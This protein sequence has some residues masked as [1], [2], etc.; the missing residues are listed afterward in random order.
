[1]S[2]QESDKRAR[3]R[4][5][6]VAI[7]SAVLAVLCLGGVFVVEVRSEMREARVVAELDHLNLPQPWKA[8]A[9]QLVE[10]SS[11]YCGPS[12]RM[13]RTYRVP[14]SPAAALAT[15]EKAVM[16]AGWTVETRKQP[17][18]AP[19]HETVWRRENYNLY[20]ETSRSTA[21]VCG[22]APV[23]TQVEIIVPYDK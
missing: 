22:P 10:R 2:S 15:V 18:C 9:S 21:D 20:V 17:S 3:R 1:M 7:A 23:C 19:G 13:Y 4:A 14:V 8:S 11:P 12:F 6:R 5:G 16:A